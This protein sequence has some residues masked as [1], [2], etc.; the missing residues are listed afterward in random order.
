VD[1][2]DLSVKRV[3]AF[4]LVSAQDLLD[5]GIPLPPGMEPPARPASLPRLIRWR[6]ALGWSLWSMRRRVGFWIAGHVPDDED[7]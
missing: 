1:S 7:W 5:V 3:G 4:V 6:M 2:P